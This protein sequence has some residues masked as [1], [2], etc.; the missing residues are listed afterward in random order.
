MV[1]K[2]SPWGALLTH[3]FWGS[4]MESSVS[5]KSW[6]PL[7]VASFR[8]NWLAGGLSPWGYHAVNILL[9]AVA[10]GLFAATLGCLVFGD[11]PRR[12]ELA[13]GGGL[14]FAVHPVHVENVASVVGRADVLAGMFVLA[15][16]LAYSA[17][18]WAH[19]SR[20]SA[21]SGV[22]ALLCSIALALGGLACKENAVAALPLCFV[23]DVLLLRAPR[24]TLWSQWR[25]PRGVVVALAT[26]SMVL[27]RLAMNGF[28]QPKFSWATDNPVALEADASTRTM[29]LLYLAAR[30]VGL[31]LV[32]TRLCCDWG[33]G[34]VPMIT[35]ISDSRNFF[36]LAHLGGTVVCAIAAWRAW[37]RR[38][39]ALPALLLAMS[40]LPYLPASNLFAYVGFVIAER[41]LYI[42]SFGVCAALALALLG[43]RSGSR[44]R[45]L[46]WLALLVIAGLFARASVDRSADWATGRSLY[47]SALEVNP[48][49]PRA[50]LNLGAVLQQDAVTLSR[51]PGLTPADVAEV[52]ALRDEAEAHIRRSLEMREAHAHAHH[53]LAIVLNDKGKPAEALRHLER[54]VELDPGFAAA[55][56]QLG[57]MLEAVGRADEAEASYKESLRLDPI[58]SRTHNNYAMWLHKRERVRE[59]E[60]HYRLALV[61][62]EGDVAA[63]VASNLG[64]SLQPARL[65]ARMPFAPR[66]EVL[67]ASSACVLR[68]SSPGAAPLP[69]ALLQSQKR[70]ADA[71]PFYEIALKHNPNSAAAHNNLGL[72]YR[73]TGRW[74]AARRHFEKA[75]QLDPNYAAPRANIARLDAVTRPQLPHRADDASVATGRAGVGLQAP[76]NS[77]FV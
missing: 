23:I 54:A 74:A 66:T 36:T 24:E 25:R 33:G 71:Q 14:L 30:H 7:V 61:A 69:G 48:H 53:Y 65:C 52:Q 16:I 50:E 18:W 75:I 40:V 67:P 17:P 55:H 26:A 15:S 70:F 49:N 42:S 77:E 64:E 8:L 3:D 34:G 31:L 6:R 60:A 35:H 2:D 27:F 20:E 21:A 44:R 10:S 9:H 11:L 4:S 56:M 62:A 59:A 19:H 63:R 51:K 41:V 47:E 68:A 76:S 43:R 72:L 57:L 37:R 39:Y 32:P 38:G 13:F 46:R 22:A 45:P 12:W 73:E 29:T 28:D 5:H 58:H 1:S